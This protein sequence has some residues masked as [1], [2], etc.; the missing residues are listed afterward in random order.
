MSFGQ[1]SNYILL[2]HQKEGMQN[3]IFFQQ[4]LLLKG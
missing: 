2:P 4:T 1:E 3:G